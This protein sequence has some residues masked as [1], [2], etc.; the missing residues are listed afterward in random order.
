[1]QHVFTINSGD[2]AMRRAA[3]RLFGELQQRFGA[4]ESCHVD[5]TNQTDDEAWMA[6]LYLAT[7]SGVHRIERSSTS[8][9]V[10]L[11]AAFVAARGCLE[12]E[13]H[14]CTRITIRSA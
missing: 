6:T 5:I 2:L 7:P 13:R 14:R 3:S 8:Q 12:H 1:M 4:I 11:R 9:D 10:A